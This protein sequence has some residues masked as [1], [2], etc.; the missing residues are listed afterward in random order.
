[1][2]I[3]VLNRG[4]VEHIDL[5]GVGE[6]ATQLSDAIFSRLVETA[7]EGIAQVQS[8]QGEE[9]KA[10]LDAA[11]RK[12]MDTWDIMKGRLERMVAYLD[13]RYVH[14]SSK[15]HESVRTAEPGGEVT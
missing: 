10:A 14:L 4:A 7:D 5:K 9:V 3:W 11:D 8:A 15:L 13:G 12:L 1:M 6:Q 2:G